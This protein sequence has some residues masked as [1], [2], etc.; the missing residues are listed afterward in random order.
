[1]L[2]AHAGFLDTDACCMVRQGP[3]WA[4]V[5]TGANGIAS[6]PHTLTMDQRDSVTPPSAAGETDSAV[7]LS[8]SPGQSVS[9]PGPTPGGSDSAEGTALDSRSNFFIRHQ[10]ILNL[11]LA[12]LTTILT[13]WGFYYA[14][15]AY[16]MAEDHE[17]REGAEK[18]ALWALRKGYSFNPY[19]A[20]AIQIQNRS[21]S[22]AASVSLVS[23]NDARTLAW[24]IEGG[25][26][27]IDAHGAWPIDDL[28]ACTSLVLQHPEPE[29]ERIGLIFILNGR[30]WLVTIG[31]PL[32]P[33][34]EGDYTIRNK[35]TSI[36]I[37]INI[38]VPDK[39]GR[40]PAASPGPPHDGQWRDSIC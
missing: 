28:G 17:Q 6:S 19:G 38:T 26:T 4:G 16:V 10:V 23:W 14:R 40:V 29:N 25:K 21:S 32:I 24:T 27:T 31:Q 12:V 30:T 18:I 20:D 39:E 36:M 34:G 13:G 11:A 15:S 22:V 1:M 9:E 33:L 2:G 8:T 7:A 5:W 37:E 35:M 3:G